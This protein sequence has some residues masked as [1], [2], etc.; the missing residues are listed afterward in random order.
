[1]GVIVLAALAGVFGGRQATVTTSTGPVTVSVEYPQITR[2]GIEA[3]LRI[4]VRRDGGFD[5]PVTVAIEGDIF[6]RLDFHSW[7]PTPSAER[8][9][10]R[11]VI[12]EFDP[13]SAG[14][15]LVARLDAHAQTTQWPSAETYTIALP[16]DRVEMEIRMWVMP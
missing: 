15:T 3:P 6:D 5:G 13:P 4:E 14:E 2:P 12:V 7:F 10:G 9:D 1:M 11:F 16:D 8:A